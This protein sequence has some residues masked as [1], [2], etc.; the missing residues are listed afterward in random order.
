MITLNVEADRKGDFASSIAEDLKVIGDRFRTADEVYRIF[1]L[2]IMREDP[3]LWPV[4]WISES[5]Q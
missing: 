2:K 3:S 5:K 1:R 4:D